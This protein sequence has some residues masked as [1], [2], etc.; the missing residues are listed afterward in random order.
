MSQRSFWWR[1][2]VYSAAY[3]LRRFGY[4]M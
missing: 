4:L 1:C 2:R 3:F